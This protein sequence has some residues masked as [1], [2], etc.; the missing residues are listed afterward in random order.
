V[1]EVTLIDV[2]KV[3][4][5]GTRAVTGLS[6]D[7]ADGE[8]LVLVGPSGCG[9]TTAL[10]MVAGLEDISEG[11][12]KIGERV[13]NRVPARDRDIAMVFQ[14]YALYPHLKVYDNIAF[15]LQLRKL[16]KNEI[17]KRVNEAARV[18]G[19]EEYLQRKPRNLSGGQRQRVAMGRAIVREPQAFLMDEPLSNLDAKLRVQMRADVARIQRDLGTTTI[20]VT[21]DQVEAMT[22]GDRVAVMKKGVL[23]Q[24]A[25]PQVLY[26]H[27]VNLFVAGFIGSPAMNLLEGR[28]EEAG[29]GLR[30]VLGS[31]R[32][33][34]TADL[35]A[36]RPAIRSYVGR[37]VVVGIRPEDL[38]DAA[39][40]RGG[41]A[42]APKLS[43]TVELVESMGSEVLVHFSLDAPTVVTEDTKEL[44]KDVG[45]PGEVG[46]EPRDQTVMVARFGPRTRAREG[47][48]IE[49]VVD[50]DRLHVFDPETGLSIFNGA[51]A[52]PVS[53]PTPSGVTTAMEKGNT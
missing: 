10:R 3:Y 30:F 31:Q 1:A 45:H 19:L 38:E 7:V 35:L 16:P 8:F 48:R 46:L 43:S 42:D 34:V 41:A 24:V 44:A 15:G 39:L 50:A 17:E 9:K 52:G 14:S 47:E 27:P 29:G 25:D 6:L 23:Q 37:R 11:E 5:D 4:A 22:L 21:H 2:G 53:A 51:S 28:V 13:V 33:P 36:R 20:Y 26:E 18:L 12:V 40:V 32:V 49:A